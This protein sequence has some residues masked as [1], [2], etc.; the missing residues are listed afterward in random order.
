VSRFSLRTHVIG[1][2]IAVAATTAVTS[3]Q[4]Q[5]SPPQSSTPPR[6]ASPAAP[7]TPIPQGVPLPADYV[8][9][10]DD[11]LTIFFWREKEM[12]GDVQVRPDGRI[13]MP[14]LND[15]EAAGLTPEEL[16]VRVTQAA[17]KFFQEPTVSVVVKQINSRKVYVQGNVAKQ[18]P[19]ALS[20]PMT[21]VQMLALA[22]GI[23]EW[24]DKENIAIVRIQ[25]DG[26]S[27]R[28]RFNYEEVMKGK[29]MQQNILLK[30]GDT[31][32]VP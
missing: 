15:L 24:A 30:P 4:G 26:S 23:S 18:G 14:L 6:N 1:V 10:A 2:V 9:G 3:T 8:I 11:V 7:D 17:E 12:T 16:R 27:I 32:I 19:Q 20:G 5:S 21:V 25:K 29:K 28:L 13:S 22:G 31:I